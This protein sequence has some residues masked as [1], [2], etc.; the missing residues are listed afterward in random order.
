MKKFKN[1]LVCF[2][3]ILFF[4][5]CE[6]YFIRDTAPY[7][8]NTEQMNLLKSKKFALVGFYPF[9]FTRDG[10]HAGRIFES[11]VRKTPCSF[12]ESL[13]EEKR[14]FETYNCIV[15]FLKEDQKNLDISLDK[16]ISKYESI[17]NSSLLSIIQTR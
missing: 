7:E 13:N 3:L 1:A 11:D 6:Y 16:E 4:Q 12:C 8:L 5:N 2:F 15:S 14:N 9:D 10:R 17:F